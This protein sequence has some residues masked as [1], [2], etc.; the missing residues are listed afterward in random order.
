MLD[1]GESTMSGNDMNEADTKFYQTLIG[2][3]MWVAN[4]VRIDVA[5][6]VSKLAR[7]THAPRVGHGNRVLRLWAYLREFLID[8]ST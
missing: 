2:A 6:A 4:T 1:T 7:Y 8:G 3:A 5:V